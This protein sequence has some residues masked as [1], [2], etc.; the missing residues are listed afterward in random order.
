MRLLDL[1]HHNTVTN[2]DL[3]KD[4]VI[5]KCSQGVDFVDNKFKEYQAEA[6]QRNL[7]LGSY[8]FADGS[9]PI[10]EAEHYLK[11][12]GE[13]RKG[14]LLV[15]DYEINLP[16]FDSWCAEFMTHIQLSTGVIPYL[17]TNESRAKMTW[18]KSTAYP[19]WVARYFDNN[20]T[21]TGEPSSGAW[22]KWIIHQYTSRGHVDGI[23]GYVDLNYMPLSLEKLK[24]SDTNMFS[25]CPRCGYP[26]DPQTG[27][28]LEYYWQRHPRYKGLKLGPSNLS[29]QNYACLTCSLAYVTQEDP[30][31]VHDK[32]KAGGGYLSDGRI[33]S[34]KAAE[35]LN[36]EYKGK[37]K[38]VNYMPDWTPTIKE[39]KLGSS[40]HF[41]VRL[42]DKYNP[43]ASKTYGTLIFDPW[44]GKYLGINYYNFISYRLFKQ[45]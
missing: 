19:L 39:V 20:G 4:P 13:I 40:Q 33:I 2:W 30:L 23:K 15:L 28:P 21:R 36:L 6:R 1:S 37:T 44:V 14:E 16:N 9:D 18:I 3:I 25:K 43:V 45:K 41:V 42:I 32:L 38:D 7:Y 27:T 35:I 24:N 12:L 22:P 31:V 5:L 29:F 17:Y 11:T 10:E 26:D 34:E 8:H